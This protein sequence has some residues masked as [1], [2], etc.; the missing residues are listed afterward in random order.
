[1]S[2]SG[3]ILCAAAVAMAC[4]APASLL[5]GAQG[6]RATAP[7]SAGAPRAGGAVFDTTFA[8]ERGGTLVFENFQGRLRVR[9]GGEDPT[10]RVVTRAG[11]RAGVTVDH[12]G[13]RWL[14]RR[15][16]RGVAG[17]LE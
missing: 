3:R 10:V 9:S 15:D 13:R 14:L 5:A 16:R 6:P 4:F 2:A 1:M 7:R 17:G 11:R 12:S 8:V